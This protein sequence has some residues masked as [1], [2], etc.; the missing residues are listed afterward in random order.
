V[1]VVTASAT[2][3]ASYA[4]TTYKDGDRKDIESKHKID[5][6]NKEFALKCKREGYNC[7]TEPN[8]IGEQ[9]TI[10]VDLEKSNIPSFPKRPPTNPSSPYEVINLFFS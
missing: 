8:S 10:S 7:V 9:F 4:Y 1:G 2:G 3:S 5:M 6:G